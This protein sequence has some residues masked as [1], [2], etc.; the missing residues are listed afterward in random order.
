LV[1][2]VV[3][4]VFLVSGILVLILFGCCVRIGLLAVVLI[5]LS[6]GL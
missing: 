3:V 5:G 2:F 4:T 6:K 1:L